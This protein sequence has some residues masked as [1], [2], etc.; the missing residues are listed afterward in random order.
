NYCV[1][2]TDGAGC[3]TSAC[4]SINQ[5]PPLSVSISTPSHVCPGG[6]APITAV[7]NGG[8]A[9]YTYQ[10]NTGQSTATIVQPVGN[11]TVTIHDTSGFSCTAT[12]TVAI[13]NEPTIVITS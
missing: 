6:T 3:L 7:A 12:A 10:W 9:P 5:N 8:Q 13:S 11:Y 1:T 2:V 4:V